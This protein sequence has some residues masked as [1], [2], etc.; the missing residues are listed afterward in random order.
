MNSNS[1]IPVQCYK[2]PGQ[3]SSNNWNVDQSRMSVVTEIQGRQV[4][5]VDNQE[6]LSPVEMSSNEEHNEAELKE[7]VENEVA[8]HACS[9]MDMVGVIREEMPHVSDLEEEESKPVDVISIVS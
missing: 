4:E 2:S 5:E 1:S 6:H 8:S 9:G 7:V 3:G